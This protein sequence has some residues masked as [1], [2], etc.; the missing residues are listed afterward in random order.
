MRGYFGI[1]C[2][3]ISKAHNLG[4]MMRTANAFGASFVFTVNAAHDARKINK[5]DTSRTIKNLPYYEW[6]ALADMRLPQGC[7]LVGIELTEDSIDLPSFKHPNNCAYILGPEMG[8]LSPQMQA[9][10]AHIVKIPTKFCINV[11]LAAALTLYD[12]TLSCGGYPPRPVR[13]GGPDLAAV[14]DWN[15]PN[16]SKK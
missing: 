2:E 12:R 11:S 13:P 14:S 4:A 10:C 6:D 1:G 7:A 16:L 3:G 5:T 15:V 9:R 8:S